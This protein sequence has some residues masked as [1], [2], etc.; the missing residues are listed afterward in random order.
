MAISNNK[1]L[2]MAYQIEE[3]KL[4]EKYLRGDET[5]S[6]EIVKDDLTQSH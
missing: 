6:V 1:G 3:A 5:A 4:I 2:A